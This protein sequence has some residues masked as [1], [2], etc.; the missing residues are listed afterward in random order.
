MTIAR[1]SITHILRAFGYATLYYGGTIISF[2]VSYLI[3]ITSYF[4]MFRVVGVDDLIERAIVLAIFIAT[5]SIIIVHIRTVLVVT[6]GGG[7]GIKLGRG[8]CVQLQE[9]LIEVTQ[10]LKV[11]NFDRVYIVPDATASVLETSVAPFVPIKRRNLLIGWL[12]LTTLSR[13]QLKAVIAHE[14]AHFNNNAMV[15]H[16]SIYRTRLGISNSLD[17]I[18]WL[19]AQGKSATE[20]VQN[21]SSTPVRLRN[22]LRSNIDGVLMFSWMIGRIALL[23]YE[24]WITS[25]VTFLNKRNKLINHEA[26]HYCD[27]ISALH[28]GSNTV[29]GALQITTRAQ[30]AFRYTFTQLGS[31]IIEQENCYSLFYDVYDSFLKQFDPTELKQLE[32][33]SH[34]THPSFNSRKEKINNLPTSED[35]SHPLIPKNNRYSTLEKKLTLLAFVMFTLDT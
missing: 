23:P 31:Q 3:L 20:R 24:F 6:P 30:I 29:L 35:K 21:L 25:Y 9:L 5:V 4:I 17:T 12:L 8:E 34:N 28:Y 18:I 16:R 19:D 22:T 15:L 1:P 10:E 13:Q 26:E 2:A 7:F 33:E 27:E 32:Q 11:D 14:L